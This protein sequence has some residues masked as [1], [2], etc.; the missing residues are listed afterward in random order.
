MAASA[1]G[2][3][4]DADGGVDWLMRFQS[5]DAGY[6]AF[7]AGI[8]TVIFGRATFDQT[9][10]FSG[11]W[12][13]ADKRS[14]VVTSRPIDDPP[15]GVEPWTVGVGALIEKIRADRGEDGDAWVIG[16][17]ALQAAFIAAGALDTLDLF[18][19]PVLLGDGVR[20][21]P[22]SQIS[23]LLALTSVEA[24]GRGM[25]RLSYSVANE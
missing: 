14:I 25:V 9:R 5:V 3:I 12:A 17:A 15:K 21:F 1:D 20:M 18:V 2:F 13:F 22:R 19:V 16:G 11:D 8:G 7:I 24:L 6:D 10:G 23:R 4:A